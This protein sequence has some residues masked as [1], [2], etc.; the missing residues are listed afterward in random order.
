MPRKPCSRP[1]VLEILQEL[2]R[3][4]SVNPSLA[5]EEGHGEGAIADVAQ[6]W[7]AANGVRSWLEEAVPG[8]ALRCARV[9][10]GKDTIRI[11]ERCRT[12]GFNRLVFFRPHLDDAARPAATAAPILFTNTFRNCTREPG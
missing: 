6:K 12:R 2:I 9:C 3:T 4:P 10:L 8:V 7:L 1:D 5:P 11:R